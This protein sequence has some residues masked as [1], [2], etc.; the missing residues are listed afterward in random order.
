LRDSCPP[1]GSN[2]SGISSGR[3]R[4]PLAARVARLAFAA[5]SLACLTV[6]TASPAFAQAP[7]GSPALFLH[8]VPGG[9]LPD[10]CAAALP[11][12]VV[13]EAGPDVGG[14]TVSVAAGTN[15]NVYVIASGIPVESGLFSVSFSL[16]YKWLAGQGVDVT[17]WKSCFGEA[18]PETGWPGA[19]YTLTIAATPGEGC[20]VPVQ[21]GTGAPAVGTGNVVVAVLNVLAHDDDVLK[22]RG[23]DDGVIHLQKC[24]GEDISL[25]PSY[26]TA[27]EVGFGEMWGVSPCW[28]R[29]HT[30]HC[31]PYPYFACACCLPDN[32]CHLVDYDDDSLRRC[33]ND[34]GAIKPGG[35]CTDCIVP[36]VSRT[37]SAIKSRVE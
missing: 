24:G 2:G 32:S 31:G 14:P 16:E 20:I 22:L 23:A 12:G 17:A 8:A 19:G 33:H 7:V 37:W 25:T 6:T 9:R 5:A 30:A 11:G 27:G 1:R 36:V 29:A 35:N 13:C 28:R 4:G 10:S 34:Y 18:L 21:P 15:Y 26:D 3:I